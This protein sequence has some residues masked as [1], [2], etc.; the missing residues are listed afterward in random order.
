MRA[1]IVCCAALAL[2]ACAGSEPTRSEDP[3]ALTVVAEVAMERGDCVAATEAYA[4]AAEKA[5]EL[6]LTRRA[7]EVAV[8]C[9]QFDTAARVLRRWRAQAPDDLDAVKLAGVID[10]ELGRI[11][12]ASKAFELALQGA[13]D[14]DGLLEVLALSLS[15]VDSY[16]AYAAV[17]RIALEP[18]W[19]APALVGVAGAA[20][21]AYDFQAAHRLVDRALAKDDSLGVAW[22]LRARLLATDGRADEAVRSAREAA[23]REGGHGAFTL[24]EV[25]IA[26]GRTEEAYRE[27]ERLQRDDATS[28][29]ADRRLALLAFR[30]G[31]DK[32]AERRFTARLRRGE[33]PGESLYYLA[34]LAERQND[35]AIALQF[36]RQMSRAGASLIATARFST[37]LLKRGDREFALR[38]LDDYA[39]DHPDEALD[40][41]VAKAR[42]LV[43]AGS[44]ADA[45]ALLD[46]A[47]DL[48]PGHANLLYQRALAFESDGKI[49]IA[50][51]ELDK[52]LKTRPAD[53]VL[54]NA[55]GYTLA[56]HRRN[57]GRAEDLIR[58]ALAKTPDNPAVLDSLG[59]VHYRRG[60]ANEAL[61]WLERA[62]R[63]SQD[64]EIAAHWGEVL[65]TLG[66]ESEAR[67]VWARA[68]ARDPASALLKTTLTRFIP[69]VS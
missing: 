6:S 25:F 3:S 1:S 9:E 67:A 13:T 24:G 36:Y 29:E 31:D 10:L 14:D 41:T 16:E 22:A 21:D 15:Q 63:I 58:S 12:D 32:E 55:L 54:L 69:P 5:D 11:D 35:D 50:V 62:H 66:R 53:P 17:A 28:D 60:R 2:S 46:A 40:V 65:W 37:V 38:Q 64:S 68:L 20:A 39:T 34:A 19:G 30:E 61:P 48:Y 49:D 45:V 51:T 52:L 18:R 23:T 26:L 4:S 57:L 7:L 42:L 47:L 59:W 43:V 8:K 27:F 56:D 33:G 44:P